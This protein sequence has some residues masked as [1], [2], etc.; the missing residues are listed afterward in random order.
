MKVFP[1]SDIHLEAHYQSFDRYRGEADIVVCAGDM[2]T[3]ARGPKALRAI[4][5]HQEILYTPGNHE[6]YGESIQH[7]D[8]LLRQECQEYGIHFLQRNT[9]EIG[10]ITFAGCTLWTDFLLYGENRQV[11]AIA[12]TQKCL[13]DYHVIYAD[14]KKMQIITPAD[15]IEIHKKDVA[16]LQ[17]KIESQ[18]EGPLIV[19]TH[20]GPSFKNVHPSY[21]E[22][23]VSAGFASNL[24]EL[25]KRSGAKYWFS[26]HSHCSQHFRIGG[27]TVMQNCWLCSRIELVFA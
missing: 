26:G 1:L 21:T 3:R 20:H 15:T 4:F 25:V 11:E 10:G 23:I 18:Q 2:H 24:D 19:M 6:Y 14:H 9:V 27:T 7:Q 5:D 22:D 17:E 8:E 13:R 12:E 16:W